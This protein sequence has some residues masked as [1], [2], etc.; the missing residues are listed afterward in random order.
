MLANP[1]GDVLDFIR[2]FLDADSLR[3][4]TDE[5]REEVDHDDTINVVFASSDPV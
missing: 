3:V 5:H 2:H 1:V 4:G